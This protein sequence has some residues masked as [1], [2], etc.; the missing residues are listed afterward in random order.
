MTQRKLKRANQ[1]KQNKLNKK[2][3][4]PQC[5]HVTASGKQCGRKIGTGTGR[6]CKQH[7]E[8]KE[9]AAKE[10]TEAAVRDHAHV[11]GVIAG[12]LGIDK[13]NESYAVKVKKAATFYNGQWS[14]AEAASGL[15]WTDLGK[16]KTRVNREPKAVA[17]ELGTSVNSNSWP[18]ILAAITKID[19]CSRKYVAQAEVAKLS[20]PHRPWSDIRTQ[21]KAMDTVSKAAKSKSKAPKK[22]SKAQIKAKQLADNRAQFDKLLKSA[23]RVAYLIE[24]QCSAKPHQGTDTEAKATKQRQNVAKLLLA[25]NIKTVGKDNVDWHIVTAD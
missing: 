2:S 17:K 5:A 23:Y 18:V 25:N 8:A 12:A 9:K 7:F 3:K 21:A 4:Q 24:A 22:P 13:A 16:L 15:H 6:Y 1:A 11:K 10:R 14:E 19:N 20:N